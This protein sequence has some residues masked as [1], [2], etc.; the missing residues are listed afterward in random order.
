MYDETRKA[1]SE[2][3]RLLEGLQTNGDY[4]SIMDDECGRL[5]RSAREMM[6]TI[7]N[8]EATKR[9]FDEDL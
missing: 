4:D 8:K 9:R 3:K 6:E 5:K 7:D 1:I 2:G